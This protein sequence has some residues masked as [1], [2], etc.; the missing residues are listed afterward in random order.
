MNYT[1]TSD[2]GRDYGPISNSSKVHVIG[3][4]LKVT[5]TG[6][7]NVHAG[8]G[9]SYTVTITNL[10][11]DTANNVTF[12]DNFISSWFNKLI[13]PEY[14]LNGGSYTAIIN[15]P[16][17]LSLGHDFRKFKHSA[18]NSYSLSISKCWCHK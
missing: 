13:N 14:S 1:S 15:N 9:I 7:S 8:Q 17:T 10:G 12:T 11:P 16:W 5:K 4:D 6:T 18:D 2:G 3:A